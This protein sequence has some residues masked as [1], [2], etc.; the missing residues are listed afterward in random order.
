MR[1]Q[2]DQRNYTCAGAWAGHCRATGSTCSG[3]WRLSVSGCCQARSRSHLQ[4]VP[5]PG[6]VHRHRSLP[7]QQ[8]WLRATTTW[9]LPGAALHRKTVAFSRGV[10]R[11]RS[12]RQRHRTCVADC[13]LGLTVRPPAL[14][15]TYFLVADIRPLAG[16]GSRKQ[17]GAAGH[18]SD[19]GSSS[20]NGSAAQN[21][22][23]ADGA[24]VAAAGRGTTETDVDFCQRL[25]VEA[26]V[27]LIPVRN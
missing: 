27:T 1:Q 13:S 6:I 8:G 3:G 23:P 7:P 20:A 24:G 4:V 18:G 25:T 14:Q 21:G 17:Q 19:T 15:G 12:A 22:R 26:G 10:I 2:A 9:R 16:R 11:L 5:A